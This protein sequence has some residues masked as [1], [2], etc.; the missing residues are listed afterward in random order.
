MSNFWKQ[1]VA[2]ESVDGMQVEQM[3]D[4]THEGS[5]F[6][7]EN[8]EVEQLEK[9]G[10]ALAADMEQ[11]GSIGNYIDNVSELSEDSFEA[12]N[13]AQE[14]I[15]KRWGI[16]VAKVAQ[17]SHGS[18]ADLR[19]VAQEANK[20]GKKTLWS[21]FI[22]WLK[23]MAAKLKERWLKFHNAGKTLTKRAKAYKETIKGLGKKKD[24]K[25]SG[26]WIS[27]LTVNNTF[28]GND[29]SAIKDQINYAKKSQKAQAAILETVRKEILGAFNLDDDKKF[30]IY[31]NGIAASQLVE[32]MKKSL[33]SKDIIG[34][35]YVAALGEG[36]NFTYELHDRDGGV[37]DEIDTPTL[38]ALEQIVG[39]LDNFGKELEG[40]LL[41]FRKTNEL[42]NKV[43]SL[44][45][46][47]DKAI[48]GI[49][50]GLSKG[51]SD[52]FTDNLGK[53]VQSLTTL[54]I[55]RTNTISQAESF[56]WKNL[57][58]GLDS[59]IKASIAAYGKK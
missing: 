56:I 42:R 21:R 37:Q 11:L 13:V 3:D 47:L 28:I 43:V 55:S 30:S 29:G 52:E 32:T 26:G 44:E 50:G 46:K 36:E 9:D 16:N 35:K 53:I 18:A 22:A 40:Q 38:N 4:L 8:G 34:N 5:P 15:R 20:E 7:V 51:K 49:S 14:S 48:S 23:E 17:E 57:G 45:S 2:Q 19:L 10:D 24:D 25:V 41:E 58:T 59:Y 31:N 1:K 39:S 33:D 27:Q 54:T 12:I 6:A